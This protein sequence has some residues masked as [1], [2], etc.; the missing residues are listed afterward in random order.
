MTLSAPSAADRLSAPLARWLR[1]G[2]ER[3]KAALLLLLLA[4]AGGLGLG[5]LPGAEAERAGTSANSSASRSSVPP[6]LLA[7]ATV[8]EQ[9]APTPA[10]TGGGAMLPPASPA[11][12]PPAFAGLLLLGLGVCWVGRSIRT[13]PRQPTGPPWAFSH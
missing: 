11:L 10:G 9:A 8:A 13:G 5:G 2:P 1:H 4:L 12:P 3:A 6:A 7:V